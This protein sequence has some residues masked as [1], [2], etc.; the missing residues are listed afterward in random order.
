MKLLEYN[1]TNS[2]SAIMKDNFIVYVNFFGNMNKNTKNRIVT[3]RL[4]NPYLQKINQNKINS[5][6]ANKEDKILEICIVF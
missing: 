3:N 5:I 2:I 6:N 4:F 1:H